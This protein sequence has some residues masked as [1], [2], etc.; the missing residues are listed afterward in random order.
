[1]QT[2]TWVLIGIVYLLLVI[3]MYG[4]ITGENI[5]QNNMIHEEH[6]EEFVEES[7]VDHSGHNQHENHGTGKSQVITH[8]MYQE[9]QLMI[10]LEDDEGNIPD[11]DISHEKEMH[12]IVVSNDLKQ[13]LHLHPEKQ[14]EGVFVINQS[15]ADGEYQIFVD[16]SPKGKLYTPSANAI[17]VGEVPTTKTQLEED[18]V[19]TKEIDGKTVTL[20]TVEAIVD[21]PVQLVFDLHGQ[22][23]E[24]YL[25]ALGHVVILDEAVETFI[26]VHPASNDETRFDAHFTQSGTY[27]LWAE[28]QFRDEGIIA[29]PF[30]I[31][32]N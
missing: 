19:W 9:D 13:Y 4:F 20:E 5:F 21:E 16:V 24:P 3:G 17:Q 30:V 11:L 31:E 27:K 7:D 32:V 29:F 15:L 1:M 23:P 10:Q 25:G 8:V 18:K 22:T 2:K 12:V 28:F 14:G 6:S 26:H